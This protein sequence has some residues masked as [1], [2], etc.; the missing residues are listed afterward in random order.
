MRH[1]LTALFVSAG[2]SFSLVP[3]PSFAKT[4]PE[5]LEPYKKYNAALKKDDKDAAYKYALQAW[6]AAEASLGD[7]ETTGALAYNYANTLRGKVIKEQLEAMERSMDLALLEG[8]RDPI[9]YMERGVRLAELRSNYDSDSISKQGK[10]I[11]KVIEFAESEGLTDATFYGDALAIKAGHHIRF[12]REKKALEAAQKA[13][14]VYEN[15]TDGY[16]TAYP[17]FAALYEGFG[18]EKNED[19]F[20]AAMSYQKVIEYVEGANYSSNPVVGRA[21]GRWTHMRRRLKKS[22]ELEAAKENGLCDCFP[23]DVKRNESV[24]P[25]KRMPPRFPS[26]A[27]RSGVSGYSIVRFDLT[28]DGKVKDPEILV[29]WPPDLYEKSSLLSLNT[30]QYSA[31]KPDE[32][33]ED[34]SNI[35]STI[36]YDIND[37]YGRPVY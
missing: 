19:I 31:R 6:K 21:L 20:E 25:I 26:K 1:F 2:L 10:T 30:W 34:R 16:P 37:K 3:T 4:P 32:T 8:A 5:V 33:D 17:V 36:R 11:D 15:A 9:A 24:E 13:N 35:V 23:Y 27:L 29:S 28:D 12:R 7:H 14:A 22:G 18:H